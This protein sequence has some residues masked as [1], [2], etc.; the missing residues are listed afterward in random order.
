M[1]YEKTPV[2][3]K[4]SK[5]AVKQ[6]VAKELDR[7]STGAIIWHLVKRHKFAI[8]LI[9]AITITVLY[10]APFLPSLIASALIQ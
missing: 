4:A 6:E 8:V 5:Q 2:I 3:K 10:L 1:T 9:Y 7:V